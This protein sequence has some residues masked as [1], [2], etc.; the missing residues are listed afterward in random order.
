MLVEDQ[1]LIAMSLEASLEEAGFTVVASF[2]SSA[3]ALEWLKDETPELALLDVMLKDGTCVQLARELKNRGVPF[4]IYSGLRP[5]PDGPP[6]FREVPWL[7]KPIGREDLARTLDL[8]ARTPDDRSCA[9][10]AALPA[11][12]D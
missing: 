2:G 10:S 3:R 7:E 5:T 6:E 4:A 8:L 11:R 9:A 1:T 12:L